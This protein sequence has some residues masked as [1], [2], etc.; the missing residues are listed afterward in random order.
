MIQLFNLHHGWRELDSEAGDI[1]GR[2]TFDFWSKIVRRWLER[3]INL[4]H[5]RP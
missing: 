2:A 4:M 5:I 1:S 3:T